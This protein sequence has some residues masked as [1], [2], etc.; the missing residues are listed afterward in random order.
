MRPAAGFPRRDRPAA[1]SIHARRQWM[2]VGRGTGMRTQTLVVLA[3][4][5]ATSLLATVLPSR[6]HG[7]GRVLSARPAGADVIVR[8]APTVRTAQQR[9]IVRAAGGTVTRD[10]HLIDGLGA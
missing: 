3:V 10:L 8:F 6:S 1:N 2:K 7:A 4:L 5:V 9:A